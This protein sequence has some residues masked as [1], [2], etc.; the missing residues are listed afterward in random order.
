LD[1]SKDGNGNLIESKRVV[2]NLLAF[3]DKEMGGIK[4]VNLATKE[5]HNDKKN[6]TC[7]MVENTIP[8]TLTE[9]FPTKLKLP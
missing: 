1:V 5:A 3:E 8:M 9:C 7:F 4:G 2:K 6:A